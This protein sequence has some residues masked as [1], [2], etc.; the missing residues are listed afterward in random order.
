MLMTKFKSNFN[1]NTTIVFAMN[2]NSKTTT[3]PTSTVE[4][5][6]VTVPVVQYFGG[7]CVPMNYMDMNLKD[8]RFWLSRLVHTVNEL[9]REN[10]KLRQDFEKSDQQS[11]MDIY[12]MKNTIKDLEER[13]G[14]HYHRT[15]C[16]VE[17][18]LHKYL[19]KTK[20]LR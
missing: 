2:F 7:T 4:C 20:L 1:V 11:Q 3:T 12:A 9:R 8:S 10:A 5:D 13:H 15:T 17:Y 16:D 14:G 6:M 19:L 18:Y